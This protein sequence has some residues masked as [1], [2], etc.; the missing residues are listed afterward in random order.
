MVGIWPLT[1]CAIQTERYPIM[2][3]LRGDMG[4]IAIRCRAETA[5]TSISGMAVVIRTAPF[6]GGFSKDASINTATSHGLNDDANRGQNGS[7]A[8]NVGGNGEA[9]GSYG[10]APMCGSPHRFRFQ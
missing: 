7:W 8:P 5:R 10:K 9:I 3:R 2:P 6:P 4:D 1:D